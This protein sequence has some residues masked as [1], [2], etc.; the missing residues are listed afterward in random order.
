M[1]TKKLTVGDK[2][3]WN[4]AVKVEVLR[5]Y[6]SNKIINARCSTLLLEW[7]RKFELPLSESFVSVESFDEFNEDV[8]Y[9]GEGGPADFYEEDEDPEYIKAAFEQGIT[10][11]DI[12]GVMHYVNTAVTDIEAAQK[13]FL[14]AWGDTVH[15]Q[16]ELDQLLPKEDQTGGELFDE[17]SSPL[18]EVNGGRSGSDSAGSSDDDGS[19]TSEHSDESE[20][21]REEVGGFTSHDPDAT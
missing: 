11:E 12:N 6:K 10:E 14:A 15:S 21:R 19:T 4:N 18:L 3:I 13:M 2:F 9:W 7:V 20:V 5:T 16:E 1:E 8:E 17:E